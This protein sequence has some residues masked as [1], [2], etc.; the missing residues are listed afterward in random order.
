MLPIEVK[1]GKDYT[2][3]SALDNFMKVPDY[4]I[5]SALVLSDEREIKTKNNITYAPVYNIMFISE[6]EFAPEDLIF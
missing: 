5:S 4:H 3:H 6:K 1:S 2:K